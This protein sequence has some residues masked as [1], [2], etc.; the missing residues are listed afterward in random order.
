MIVLNI[1]NVFSK[2]K[3][4]NKSFIYVGETLVI[5]SHYSLCEH[6]RQEKNVLDLLFSESE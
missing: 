1:N 4:C 5:T 2:C 3:I 6:P